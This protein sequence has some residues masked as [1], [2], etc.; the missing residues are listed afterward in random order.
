MQFIDNAS[1]RATIQRMS[2]ARDT[3]FIPHSHTPVLA[4]TFPSESP[5]PCL[6][7]K[8]Y[9]TCC[10]PFHAGT[11]WPATAQALMRARYSAYVVK[12]ID[13]IERTDHPDRRDQFD[14][15]A[16]EQWASLST[17]QGLEIIASERG[18]EKDTDGIV[19][20]R[21]HFTVNGQKNS[22][23]ERAIFSQVEGRWYFVDGNRPAQKP[24]V[25]PDNLVGRND[26]CSCG[27][28]KKFKKCCGK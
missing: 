17:W 20:F 21:A 15:K 8:A 18:G 3:S 12:D 22:H 27:S 9:G 2:Q 4:M 23:H 7:E 16:A 6:S 28:G 19:E 11:T 25:H 10:G 14:R 13:F 5:C 1:T 26:P 24:F